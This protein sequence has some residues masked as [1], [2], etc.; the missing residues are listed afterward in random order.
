[1]DDE[2][3]SNRLA[4]DATVLQQQYQ[5]DQSITLS[6]YIITYNQSQKMLCALKSVLWCDEII[7]LDSHS[8]DDT[9]EQAEALG[10][11]VVQMDFTGFGALRNRA[12]AECSG[13][14]I[15]S[16]DSD[17]YCT[18]A[19]REEILAVIRQPSTSDVY[20]IPRSN[21]FM[22]RWI[23]YSGWYP[24]YRQPQLFR[25]GCLQYQLDPVHEGYRLLTDIPIAYLKH[26]MLQMPFE[27]VSEMLKKADRY[28][29]L[30]IERLKKKCH[31]ASMFSAVLHGIWAF[32]RHYMIKMG[33]RDGWP[34]LVIALGVSY[35]TFYR[36]TKFYEYKKGW[37]DSLEQAISL[38]KANTQI[39]TG[40]PIPLQ[41]AKHAFEVTHRDGDA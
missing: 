13:R 5:R 20:H 7:V 19:L 12:L 23:R 35:G 22:G 37:P 27:N 33:F 30:G 11:R 2:R 21:Y 40:I 18:P 8:R 28:S 1:M 6:A 17:E 16:I 26:H 32:F 14:W 24:D 39:K 9:V 4:G 15:L 25:K 31:R 3:L 10:A 34:G 38:L 29:T 41:D 36:Y